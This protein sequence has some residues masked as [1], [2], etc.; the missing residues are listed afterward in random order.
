MYHKNCSA[1]KTGDST[2]LYYNSSY[3]VRFLVWGDDY[4]KLVGEEE[5]RPLKV[6][7][8]GG[9][10]W[11]IW[12][13]YSQLPIHIH[14]SPAEAGKGNGLQSEYLILI[15]LLGVITGHYF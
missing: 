1:T 4:D 13:V 10:P 2:I 14:R 7:P 9:Y 3:K 8:L 11:P 6:H 12:P 15:R 5:I